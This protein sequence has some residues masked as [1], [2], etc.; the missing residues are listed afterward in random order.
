MERKIKLDLD[1]LEIATFALDEGEKPE[2]GEVFGMT[3]V[4]SCYRTLC[5]P[6][7]DC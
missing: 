6:T 2:G 7:F 3:T 1:E 4:D 5:C